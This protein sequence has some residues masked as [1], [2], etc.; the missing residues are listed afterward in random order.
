MDAYAEDFGAHADFVRSLPC[1]VRRVHPRLR[2]PCFGLVVACHFQSRGAGGDRF[3]LFPA[4]QGHHQEQHQVGI[5]SF[6]ELYELDLAREVEEICLE[7]PELSEDERE[8][9]RLRL[10]ALGEHR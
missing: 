9:A 3:S 5:V 1:I 7:D 2:T 4:C 10:A 8:A 6:Q